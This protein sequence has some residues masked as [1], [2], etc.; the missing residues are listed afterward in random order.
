SFLS[1]GLPGSPTGDHGRDGA[2]E[3]L[4]VEPG[5]PVL[6]VVEIEAHHLVKGEVRATVD[7]PESGQARLD[8][9]SLEMPIL[10]R[11]HLFRDRWTR[12]DQAH[13]T[14]EHLQELREL[15][16]RVPS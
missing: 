9:Q 7:L 11:L 5:R 14:L 16:E 1:M 12:S 6:R 3:N 2:Q 8:E 15:I 4:G 13:V 10:I